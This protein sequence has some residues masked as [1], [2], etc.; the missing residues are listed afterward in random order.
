MSIS[1][2]LSVIA[3][4]VHLVY[5]SGENYG[6][7]I[8]YD[9]GYADGYE[10]G[11][12]EGGGG[13]AELPSLNVP[14]EPSDIRLGKEA[15]NADGKKVVGTMP[16][17]IDG[18]TLLTIDE[19]NFKLMEGYHSECTVSVK[20]RAVTKAKALKDEIVTLRDEKGAFMSTVEIEPATD[21]YDEGYVEGEEAGRQSEYD[22][23]W[24]AYQ[25]N[26]NRTSYFC[27]FAGACW[28]PETFKPKY[29]IRIVETAASQTNAKRMFQY[30]ARGQKG[31]T[32][33]TACT[34]TPDIVDF[35]E[36]KNPSDT[37]A[38][39]WFDEVTVDFGNAT[40]LS[41]TFAIGDGGGGISKIN[42]RVTE[43]ATSFSNAFNYASTLKDLI[44]TDDSVIAASIDVK[45][46]PL[47]KAS[48]KSI[49]NALSPSVTATLSVQ[50]TAVNAAFP[51]RTEWD[52]LF[53]NK[54]NWTI[55][56]V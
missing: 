49:A 19:P 13:N 40:S 36:C 43:K 44:F 30:F 21:V 8:G 9:F 31:T 52:A 24:D 11:K 41:G 35:S 38:N 22:R 37:F 26:G 54:P 16:E 51:D 15:I 27:A 10:D 47:S 39:A 3:E 56:E 53:A 42:I 23:F 2:K 18:N 55:T 20:S 29:P 1:E 12:K 34:I 17:H 7:K 28:T 5:L 48:F 6:N 32:G 4:N 33:A 45:R 25:Q 46:S 14:A 50:K